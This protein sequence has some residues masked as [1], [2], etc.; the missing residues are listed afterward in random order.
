[1][2]IFSSWFGRKS[3]PPAG[4]SSQ[5]ASGHSQN[6]KVPPGSDTASRRKMLGVVLRDTLNRH[7]IPVSWIGAEMLVTTSRSR[8]SGIHW[9]LQVKH[10]DPR[11]MTHAVALQHQLIKRVTTFDPMAANWLMG[12][13]WQFALQDESVC[14][15]LPHPGLWTAEPHEPTAAAAPAAPGGSGD[16]IAGPVLIGKSGA[17]GNPAETQKADLERLMA[18]R[19]ADFQQHAQGE[20]SEGPDATQPMYQK[21]QPMQL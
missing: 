9:R 2:G 1:M 4:P 18:V 8:E 12:I 13:S 6:S 3:A 21:T 5:I 11:L 15:S 14:P 10:W 17:V 7:G 16:V 20:G 19:D